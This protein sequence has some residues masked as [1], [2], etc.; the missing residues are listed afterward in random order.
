MRR[1][2]FMLL[3]A[4]IAAPGAAGFNPDAP[5]VLT[6][7][8]VLQLVSKDD[9]MTVPVSIGNERGGSGGP[10]NFIIDTGA[11]RT[12]ISRELANVLN[13]VRG[14]D[15][16][17]TAMGGRSQVR[18]AVI[19]SIRVS[20]LGGEKIEAPALAARHLGAPGMLGLD[21]LQGHKVSIDFTNATMTVSPSVKRRRTITAAPD[22][23]VV[24]ARSYLGQLVVTDAQ[25]QG[26]PIR[27][28]L[29]TGSQVSIGNAALQKLA[30]GN[31]LPLNMIDVNGDAMQ[32]RYTQ[33]P[34]VNF[35][36]LEIRNLPVAFAAAAPFRQFRLDKKPAL[37]L[38]MDAL[39]LF[40]KVDIDFANREL[41][42]TKLREKA[43]AGSN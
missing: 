35:A 40:A 24:R 22:E 28:V 5:V 19:P 30:A 41:R 31:G 6:D 39:A 11:Q 27:I 20:M 1:G 9:R 15:V 32:V 23:I 36:G 43:S 2:L 26:Q 4:A 17:M 8:Q 34:L 38:G 12:V 16:M 37:L 3:A 21:S 7:E 14:R 18:T 10:W 25:Y 33:L 13:L 29:D 42:L